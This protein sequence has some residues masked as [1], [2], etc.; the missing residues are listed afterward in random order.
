MHAVLMQA[1][2]A[3]QQRA[4]LRLTEKGPRGLARDD[5]EQ[6][7]R[8]LGMGQGSTETDLRAVEGRRRWEGWERAM[9]GQGWARGG[10]GLGKGRGCC[11]ERNR[12]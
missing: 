11:V 1:E 5:S 7:E 4:M 6:G 10:S 12:G 9:R 2:V 8:G 3:Q